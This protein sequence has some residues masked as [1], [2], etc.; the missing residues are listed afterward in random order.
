MV[1]ISFVLQTYKKGKVHAC[2]VAAAPIFKSLLI[3]VASYSVFS[4]ISFD[5][6]W[7]IKQ[8][9]NGRLNM[10]YCLFHSVDT[11]STASCMRT[12]EATVPD[13]LLFENQQGN[14]WHRNELYVGLILIVKALR[15]LQ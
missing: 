10:Y 13:V 8:V 2:H 9:R 14:V 15:L 3:M 7:H 6:Q 12:G 4:E 11:L 5:D 1:L